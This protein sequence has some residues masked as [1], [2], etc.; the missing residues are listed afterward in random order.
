M[1]GRVMAR[2]AALARNST[3]QAGLAR[4]MHLWRMPMIQRLRTRTVL[5]THAKPAL[6]LLG[7]A[8][9]VL[10]AVVGLHALFSLGPGS[11]PSKPEAVV[12]PVEPVPATPVVEPPASPEERVPCLPPDFE[13]AK[14]APPPA[15]PSVLPPMENVEPVAL[16]KLVRE[17][18]LPPVRL[19]RTPAQVTAVPTLRPIQ[20]RLKQ[21]AADVVVAFKKSEDTPTRSAP[22][23]IALA[24]EP[25]DTCED[26]IN[27]PNILP[28]GCASC[29]G[30]GGVLGPPLGPPDGFAIGGG[31]CS[32]CGGATCVPG[33]TP[34]YPCSYHSTL[35]RFL[36]GVYE[37]VCCPD[38]CYEPRWTPVTDASFFTP[39]P[40]PITTQRFRWD[41][42]M[43][44]ILPDRATYFWSPPPLGPNVQL[45]NPAAA[46]YRAERNI[47]YNDLSVYTEIATNYIAGFVEM[48]YRSLNGELLGHAAGFGDI[49]LGTKSLL[50]DCELFQI[51]FQFKTY[52]LSGNFSKGLG[53]GHV[54]L[55]PSVLLGIRISP[56]TY[57][58]TQVGEWIPFG[59]PPSY[60]GSILMANASLNQVLWRVLPNVPLIG[61]WEVQT[62]SFQDGQYT[63]PY[64]GPWQKASGYTYINAG[65]GLRLFVCDRLDFGVGSSFAL[66]EKHFAETLF[67]SEFRVRY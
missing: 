41:S 48:P 8:A 16:P 31:G 53:T 45:S 42:G 22:I 60:S 38:P 9:F 47:N 30:G 15:G 21:V 57:L 5:L 55:E 23:H 33:K 40:R 29:G 19:P 44:L 26:K 51:A 7:M 10:A 3:A 37:C 36:C 62:L 39:A 11:P 43:N 49:N 25:A 14:A 34:C 18:E 50:Y 6:T 4:V 1:H 46:P 32:S 13:E 64:L 61:T 35:G 59:T 65:P 12:K 27:D 20:A 58:Q 56:D 17:A 24:E 2:L 63:D 67:R 66:T 54:S 52:I 28:V